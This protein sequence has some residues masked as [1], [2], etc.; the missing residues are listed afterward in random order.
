MYALPGEQS[1]PGPFPRCAPAPISPVVAAVLCYATPCYAT[2][3]YAMPCYAMLRHAMPCYAVPCYAVL[4][5]AMPC[6]AMPAH[7]MPSHATPCYVAPCHAL[8]CYATAVL[9]HVLTCKAHSTRVTVFPVPGGPSKHRGNTP[10]PAPVNTD[11]TA[12]CCCLLSFLAPSSVSDAA[13]LCTSFSLGSSLL[14]PCDRSA[15]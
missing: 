7:A 4:C 11:A 9:H 5:R 10:P 14:V 2:P 12:S 3:C 1:A 8:S 13:L 6:H 15:L